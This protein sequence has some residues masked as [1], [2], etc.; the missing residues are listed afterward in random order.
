ME[1]ETHTHTHI[2]RERER[3]R[4]RER[5]TYKSRQREREWERDTHTH[6]E[7]HRERGKGGWREPERQRT[8]DKQRKKKRDK[9]S[10]RERERKREGGEEVVWVYLSV[11]ED[12]E[13]CSV[14]VLPFLNPFY[15]MPL[16][17]PLSLSL[18]KD[19]FE[20]DPRISLHAKKAEPTNSS[21]SH[22][23]NKLRIKFSILNYW[24]I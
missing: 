24:V 1:G 10:E 14:C 22:S 17:D 12:Q 5:E 20:D 2:E 23:E 4:Q 3:H 13:E 21:A 8:R 11:K 18:F 15:E 16:E 6:I 9:E 7:T 19:Q